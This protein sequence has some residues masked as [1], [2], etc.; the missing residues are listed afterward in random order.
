MALAAGGGGGVIDLDD[1]TGAMTVEQYLQHR[2]AALTEKA[3]EFT[4][5][6]VDELTVVYKQNREEIRNM[7]HTKKAEQTAK[8]K[9]G[10]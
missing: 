5:D 9:A 6:A 8:N 2:L 10:G 7:Q 4:D 3:Q 1:T